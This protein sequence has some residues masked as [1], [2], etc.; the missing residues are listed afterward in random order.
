LGHEA[1]DMFSENLLDSSTVNI[2]QNH[3]NFF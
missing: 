1:G 2:Y 3:V